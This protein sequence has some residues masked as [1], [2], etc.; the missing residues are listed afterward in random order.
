MSAAS[1]DVCESGS[2]LADLERRQDDVLAQLD[3]LD[4]QLTSILKG[5]GVTLIDD[6]EPTAAA[7]EG[8][9]DEHELAGAPA[10]RGGQDSPTLP[11][12]TGGFAKLPAEPGAADS[13]QTRAA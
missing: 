3:A 6:A 4:R 7:A 5:L 11:W 13:D 1:P 9:E 8:D 12:P 10:A 2:L